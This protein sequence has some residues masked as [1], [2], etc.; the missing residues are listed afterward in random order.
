MLRPSDHSA[1]SLLAKD[2]SGRIT[3][4]TKG[5]QRYW[6]AVENPDVNASPDLR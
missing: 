1:I 3:L 4:A 5:N 2:R 6:K